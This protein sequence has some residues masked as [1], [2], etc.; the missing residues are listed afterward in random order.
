MFLKYTLPLYI[1][2]IV[3]FVLLAGCASLDTR[4]MAVHSPSVVTVNGSPC[5]IVPNY[6]TGEVLAVT[7]VEKD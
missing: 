4:G 5:L 3:V 7:C 2:L 6:D 1:L